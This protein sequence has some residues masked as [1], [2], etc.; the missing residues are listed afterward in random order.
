MPAGAA[1]AGSGGAPTLED[2]KEF[3]VYTAARLVLFVV[4]YAAVAG[5]YV[6]VTGSRAIP[7]IWPFIVAVVISAIASAVLLRKQRD[8]FALAV[9]RR[10]ARASARFEEARAKE[11]EP[12][13]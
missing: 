11:D 12:D 5:S 9:Q 13:S 10:A 8:R 2:V 6:L 3:A 1:T 4:S 7:L